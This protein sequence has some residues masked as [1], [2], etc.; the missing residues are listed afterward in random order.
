MGF[1]TGFV[2]GHLAAVPWL[3]RATEIDPKFA[4]AYAWLGRAYGAVGESDLARETT[5]RAWE[6]RAR[7]TDQERF[8]IDFSY[9]RLVTGDLDKAIQICRLWAQTYPR[10]PIPHGFLGSSASSSLGRFQRAAEENRK[11]I[12][13]DPDVSMPYANL[14]SDYVYLNRLPEAENALERA[15]ARKLDMPDYLAHRYLIAFLKGDAAEMSRLATLAE[16][17]PE[18]E[19]WILDKEG[20]VLA[21]SGR[22]RRARVMS[23]RAIDLARRRGRREAAAQHVAAAAVREA[24]FGYPTEARLLVAPARAMSS[25]RDAQYGLALAL[26]LA[27]DRSASR[28]LADD[29]ARRFSEDTMVKFSYVPVLRAVLALHDGDPVT[30]IELLEATRPYELGYQ[31]ANSVGFA[32]SLYPIY[33]RGEAY[34]ESRQGPEAAAEFQ[35][36]L[37]HRGIVFADPIGALARLQLAR[38]LLLA[39][40]S[41]NARIAYREFLTL[42]KDADS[43]IPILNKAKRVGK[44]ELGLPI[45]GWNNVAASKN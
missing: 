45:L 12:E 38:A 39:G 31:G 6:L 22:L 21:W 13:L 10:D 5:R 3:Q 15:A 33:I 36:I 30:A 34:L 44:R 19:S 18:L 29:L 40:D 8:Y 42:W 26:A 27:G 9:Y 17:D 4:T 16:E 25:G 7:A 43:D 1:H 23:Q 11:A 41:V 24:L 32:G 37:D 20:S 14:A 35:K 2:N 28:T